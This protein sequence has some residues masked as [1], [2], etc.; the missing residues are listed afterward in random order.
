MAQAFHFKPILAYINNS[1]CLIYLSFFYFFFL[2]RVK[3]P[4]HKDII[5]NKKIRI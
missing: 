4:F 3:G 1:F 5:F 2:L